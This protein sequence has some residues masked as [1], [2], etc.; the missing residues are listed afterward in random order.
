MLETFGANLG[1]LL[2]NISLFLLCVVAFTLLVAKPVFKVLEA[3]REKVAQIHVDAEEA[4]KTLADAKEEAAQI[5]RNS[6]QEAEGYA[7]RQ[8]QQA[9]QQGKE[10]LN[11]AQSTAEG[12]LERAREESEQ[13]KADAIRQSRELIRD[14]AIW[15]ASHLARPALVLSEN[16]RAQADIM[17]IP[18]DAINIGDDVTITTAWEIP[19]DEQNRVQEAIHAKTV[20]WRINPNML[21]GWIFRSGPKKVDASILEVFK[22]MGGEILH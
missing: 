9:E 13:T 20:K 2:G 4:R 19:P 21:G 17:A 7:A 16:A 5:R 11:R 3:R 15:M 8:R 14:L 1:T 12:I 18:N 10:I 6:R 22:Q